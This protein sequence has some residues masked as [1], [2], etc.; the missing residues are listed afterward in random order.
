MSEQTYALN[1]C[2]EPFLS[3]PQCEGIFFPVASEIL[4]QTAQTAPKGMNVT[5]ESH[6]FVLSEQIRA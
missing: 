3:A 2:F 6:W 4:G 5:D 1:P